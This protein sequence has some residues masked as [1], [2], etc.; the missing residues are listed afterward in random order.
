VSVCPKCQRELILFTYEGVELLKCSE[1]L[2]F[3]F[4]EGT[5]REIKRIGFAGLHTGN[6]VKVSSD[7]DEETSPQQDLYCPECAQQLLST[8]RYAYSSDIEL[9]RCTQCKGIWAD[10]RDLI[11]IEHLLANYQESLDEARAKALPLMLKVKKQFQEEEEAREEAK[12]AGKQSLLT[13]WF[14]R[15]NPEHRKIDDIFEDFHKTTK[16]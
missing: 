4:R 12:K 2:G 3:W 9:Y 5:F 10:D 13:K 6:G 14:R 16:E 15:K 7:P 8:Y 1:C 11:D